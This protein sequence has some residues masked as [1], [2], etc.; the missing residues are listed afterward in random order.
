[1]VGE[2]I[3]ELLTLGDVQRVLQN[4]LTERISIRDMTVILEALAD[5]ARLTR[6]PDALTEYVRQALNRQI[7][8]QYRST[9]GALRVF[10]LDPS[11]EQMI[12]ENI[13]Q[14]DMGCQLILDPT[15][16]QQI[17]IGTRDLAEQMTVK[18]HQLV[19]L[20]SPRTRV[21]YRRLA[22]R[23]VPTIAV[24]SYNE[25]SSDV[26]LETVGMVSLQDECAEDQSRQYA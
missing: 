12:A 6:D 5:G 22:E 17:L 26:K 21:H 1:V 8:A 9:D 13:R 10:T 18:G 14:T 16:T 3:P 2:L 23:V 25:L 20:C 19:A 7:T 24:L 4:L 11:L 15:V